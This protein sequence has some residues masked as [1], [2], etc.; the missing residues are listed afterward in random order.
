MV[1]HKSTELNPGHNLYDR[2]VYIA[3]TIG[4][5]PFVMWHDTSENFDLEPST[6]FNVSGSTDIT[7]DFKFGSLLNGITLN[8]N[9]T[10]GDSDGTIEIDPNDS[11]NSNG[12]DVYAESLKNNIKTIADVIEGG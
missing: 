8:G 10:D 6:P 2:S 7:V 5:V 11:D 12:N 3:G 9:A 4:G 1:L